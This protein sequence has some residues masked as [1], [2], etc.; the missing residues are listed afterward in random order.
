[1]NTVMNIVNDNEIN[2]S[3]VVDHEEQEDFD[4]LDEIQPKEKTTNQ[5]DNQSETTK[6]QVLKRFRRYNKNKDADSE[7]LMDVVVNNEFDSAN[8]NSIE[9]V[10]KKRFVKPVR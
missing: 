8:N 4:D 10:E 6:N 1:M 9:Q 2:C 7:D 3:S 5:I